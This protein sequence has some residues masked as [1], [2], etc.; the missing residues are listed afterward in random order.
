[1][2]SMTIE[3]TLELIL[4]VVTAVITG[5]TGWAAKKWHWSTEDYIP[6]QNL[7]IG[8]ISA[9]LFVLT[10]L[11]TNVISAFIIGLGAAFG[12]GGLYDLLKNKEK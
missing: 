10:G 4:A 9:V 6:F 12:A 3:I 11:Q 2:R 7:A 8:I 1:M 5:F